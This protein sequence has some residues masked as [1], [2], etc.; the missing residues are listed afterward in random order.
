M[1]DTLY[2]TGN[3]FLHRFDSRLKLLMLPFFVVYCFVPLPLLFLGGFLVFLGG[4]TLLSLGF[5]ELI[6][7]F[8]MVFPLLVL[9]F[10]LTP[11]FYRMGTPLV[12][13]GEFSLITRKGLIEAGIYG[14]RFLSITVIFFLLFRTTA[15]EDILLGLAWFRFPYILMLIVSVSL[16][17]IPHLAGLYGQITAAHALRCSIDDDPPRKG[18]F[19][20]IRQVFPVL[21]SLMIQ[22]VKTIPILTMAL[23]LK[24]VGRDNPRTRLRKLPVPSSPFFQIFFSIL[25]LVLLSATLLL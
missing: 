10:L 22:S 18:P 9:I 15:M 7:P 5:R 14:C 8:R 6:A 21:V 16:R 1:I 19:S 20:R 2:R 4:M 23:E 17:Y 24:G 3:S 12:S 13:I 11:L 25:I